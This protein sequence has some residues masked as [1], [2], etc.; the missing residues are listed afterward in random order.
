MSFEHPDRVWLLHNHEK[1]W[2]ICVDVVAAT[3]MA[4]AWELDTVAYVP[5]VEL[6]H[7]KRAVLEAEEKIVKL[8]RELA[9]LKVGAE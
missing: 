8:E 5:S 9:Q 1:I 6:K 2:G 7:A 3:G 4:A